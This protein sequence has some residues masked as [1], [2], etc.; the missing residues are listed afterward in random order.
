M[1]EATTHVWQRRSNLPFSIEL[2]NQL[3]IKREK[4]VLDPIRKRTEMFTQKHNSSQAATQTSAIKINMRI[5]NVRTVIRDTRRAV[6]G[7]H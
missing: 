2:A 5:E 1:W 6:E 7:F 4:I 3:K